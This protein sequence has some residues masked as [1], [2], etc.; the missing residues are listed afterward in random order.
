MLAA[1]GSDPAAKAVDGQEPAFAV[2]W[3]PVWRDRSAAADTSSDKPRDAPGHVRIF[4]RNFG[5]AA[6]EVRVEL[7]GRPC[8][9]AQ[10]VSTSAARVWIECD[11]QEAVVGPMNHSV[12]VASRRHAL[13]RCAAMRVLPWFVPRG[14][15]TK[16]EDDATATRTS[17]HFLSQLHSRE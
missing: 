9:N 16:S 5:G 14:G 6:S 13:E 2:R 12:R 11:A 17:V 8:L 1:A 15:A 7:N 4:G 3:A 10:W